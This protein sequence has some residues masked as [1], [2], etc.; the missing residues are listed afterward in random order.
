MAAAAAPGYR[1]HGQRRCSG[2]WAR[3]VRPAAPRS[4]VP[5]HGLPRR[6]L[7]SGAQRPLRYRGGAAAGA[8]IGKSTALKVLAGKLKPNLGRFEVRHLGSRATPE[9]L[10]TRAEAAPGL[11]RW[12]MVQEG[13]CL[14]HKPRVL[15]QYCFLVP[16]HGLGWCGRPGAGSEAGSGRPV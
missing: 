14:C 7:P 13:C 16:D 8:G 10:V 15:V 2:W 12:L 4:R 11:R 1:Y 5:C 3:T 6:A 9:A